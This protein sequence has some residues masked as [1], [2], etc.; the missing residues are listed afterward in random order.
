MRRTRAALFSQVIEQLRIDIATG[1]IPVGRRFPTDR[2][3]ANRFGVSRATVREVVRVL[4]LIGLVT[5][6]RG[7]NAGVA[8]SDNA[9]ELAGSSFTSLLPPEPARFSQSIEFRKIV[10]PQAAALAAVRA[11][12]TELGILRRSLE[13]ISDTET[14]VERY[15]ESNELFHKTV[16]HATGNPY[17]VNVLAELFEAPEAVARQATASQWS[18]IRYFHG[19]ILTAIEARDTRQAEAWMEAHLAQ[20]EADLSRARYMSEGRPAVGR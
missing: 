2:Q 8:V 18:L 1:R 17:I 9:R 20:L 13:M 6:T 19:K 14:T 16:A 3:L 12:D 15:I 4:E 10:E 7:R 5:I 11:T